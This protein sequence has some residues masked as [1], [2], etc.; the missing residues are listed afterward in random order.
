[1]PRQLSK[2]LGAAGAG[3]GTPDRRGTTKKGITNVDPN[4]EKTQGTKKKN[5]GE[6]NINSRRTNVPHFL[7]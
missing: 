4:A 3:E 6:G 7:P 2:E 5:E 1:M